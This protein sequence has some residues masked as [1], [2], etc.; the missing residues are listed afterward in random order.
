M[1]Y[2]KPNPHSEPERLEAL[3]HYGIMDTPPDGAFDRVTVLAARFFNV[4]ISLVS[5]VDEDRIWFKSSFG[6]DIPQID[7]TPGLCASAIFQ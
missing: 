1:R 7:R 6:L 2:R 4:P 3:R 5:L